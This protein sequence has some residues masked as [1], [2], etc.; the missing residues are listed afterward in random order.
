MRRGTWRVNVVSDTW[1]ARAHACV[2]C[3]VCLVPDWQAGVTEEMRRGWGGETIPTE[4]PPGVTC[5]PGCTLDPEGAQKRLIRWR[6][7]GVSPLGRG[8]VSPVLP[9]FHSIHTHIHTFIHI[10]S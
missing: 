9:S 6:I 3:F 10:Y 8:L 1:L 5:D 7:H 2:Y 4:H